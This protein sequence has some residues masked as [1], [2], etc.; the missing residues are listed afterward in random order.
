[1]SM[2]LLITFCVGVAATLAFQTYGDAARQIIANSYPQ[3]GWLAPETAV[4]QTA[5][6]LIVPAALDRDRQE[7]LKTMSFAVAAVRQRVDELAAQFAAGQQQMALDF[8]AKLQAS[9]RDI[10]DKISVPAL[11][12]AAAPVRKPV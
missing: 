4:A 8:A 12:S 5:P 11:Q 3:L 9:E 10:L 2:R 7:Q 1:M 6:D